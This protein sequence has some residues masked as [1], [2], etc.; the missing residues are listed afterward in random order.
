MRLFVRWTCLVRTHTQHPA[1]RAGPRFDPPIP[2]WFVGSDEE[3]I[4]VFEPLFPVLCRDV[5]GNGLQGALPLVASRSKG[6][7][8][9]FRDRLV[10]ATCSMESRS[11]S[12]RSWSNVGTEVRLL[13]S[14]IPLQW[15]REPLHRVGERPSCR[16]I[17]SNDS[18]DNRSIK[19][20]FC[21]GNERSDERLDAADFRF[22]PRPDADT[23]PPLVQNRCPD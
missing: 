11:T 19:G 21:R 10:N 18:L 23:L 1:T 5:Q 9:S 13:S 16:T 7:G 8:K 17:R 20:F 14:T 4:L 3:T 2:Q 22:R 6:I 15:V 12:S